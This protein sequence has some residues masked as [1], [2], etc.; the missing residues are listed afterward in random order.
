MSNTR[1]RKLNMKKENEVFQNSALMLVKVSL[2][3]VKVQYFHCL[4]KKSK[5]PEESGESDQLWSPGFYGRTLKNRFS[6]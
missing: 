3:L 6:D 2:M 5:E 1:P 4:K